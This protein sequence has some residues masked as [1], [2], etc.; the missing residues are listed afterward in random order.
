M[1]ECAHVHARQDQWGTSSVTAPLSFTC[2]TEQGLSQNLEL[3][4][5]P[6]SPSVA[7]ISTSMQGCVYRQAHTMY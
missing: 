2:D 1:E 3:G 6:A 7:S 5:Q 4:T